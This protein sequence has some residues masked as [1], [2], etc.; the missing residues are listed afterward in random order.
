M[1]PLKV[2]TIFGT[3]PEA[4]KLAPVIAQLK[5]DRAHFACTV[6]VTAQH[7]TMLDQM[8]EVFGITPD[9]DLNIM[10]ENQSLFRLTQKTIRRLERIITAYEPQVILVQ[11]DTTSTFIAALAGFYAKIKV[12]HVEAGLRTHQKF[13][14]FPEEMNRRLT[15][16]LADLH[17]TPTIQSKENLLREG[18]DPQNIFLTG[19]TVVDAVL[20]ILE[21]NHRFESPMLNKILTGHRRTVVVTAHRRENWGAAFES[22]SMAILQL[23]SLYQ[24]IQ[25]V[26]PVH[27]NP[28]VR[29]PFHKKL[30][31]N[32][33]IHLIEPLDYR[34]FINL[35]GRSYFIL[36]D[37]GGIQEEAPSLR[38]PAL[39]MR[40]VTERPEGLAGG[41]LK[42]V[43]CNT[44]RIVAEARRLLDDPDYYS[45]A[46]RGGNPYGDGRAARR[47]CEA[48][49]FNFGLR[50]RRPDEFH[51]AR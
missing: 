48:L 40:E 51:S 8:L 3:R 15:S 24:D 19:N 7:R 45:E 50:G 22:I 36:T 41:C 37:S 29:Q 13:S 43:G 17:F 42:L 6:V 38:K 34:S 18:M 10:E 26:F 4:I 28:R 1:A 14:P 12:A 46:I 31:D 20:S 5:A 25:F 21:E 30:Q 47:I 27:L 35:L 49:L 16:V 11:G 2:M 9:T 33:Q 32:S 39:V 44:E 23:A